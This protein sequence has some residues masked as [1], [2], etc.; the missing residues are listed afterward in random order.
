MAKT[1]FVR[2]DDFLYEQF[3]QY[4]SAVDVSPIPY[5]QFKKENGTIQQVHQWLTTLHGISL[6]NNQLQSVT[7]SYLDITQKTF[8]DIPAIHFLFKT[9]YG[10]IF[11]K[12]I[13][14]QTKS[15]F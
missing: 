9:R 12:V 2:F 11:P 8:S 4:R 13:R 1:E 15:H 5:S 14:I 6:T 10:M 3:L 7:K